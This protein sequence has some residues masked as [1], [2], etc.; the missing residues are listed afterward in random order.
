MRFRTHAKSCEQKIF[1]N[2]YQFSI[3]INWRNNS[4]IVQK[5]SSEQ[6]QKHATQMQPNFLQ[7]LYVLCYQT[8]MQRSQR[9]S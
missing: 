2:N 4:K 1:V 8:L 7:K 6:V 9:L 3:E 5:E